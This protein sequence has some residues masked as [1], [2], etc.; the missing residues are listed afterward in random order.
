[1][2]A[3]VNVEVSDIIIGLNVINQLL[4][5]HRHGDGF[6]ARRTDKCV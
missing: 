6:P 5:G 3:D 4:S 2:L 1:M